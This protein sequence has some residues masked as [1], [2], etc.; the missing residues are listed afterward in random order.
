MPQARKQRRRRIVRSVLLGVA[1][2]SAAVIALGVS[3]Y[4]HITT[5]PEH[6]DPQTWRLPEITGPRLA[7][8]WEPAAGVLIA[9]PL[10]LPR[11]LVCALAEEVVLYVT[12]ADDGARADA[13][14]TL[15]DWGLSA[16]AYAFIRTAQGDGWYG[17][18]DWGP[19]AVFDDAGR[20][21]LA[22][23]RYIDYPVSGPDPGDHLYWLTKIDGDLDFAPDDEAPAAI[24]QVLDLPRLELPFA[25]TGGAIDTD[26]QGTAFVTEAV[27]RENAALGVP[28]R[29]LLAAAKA[30]LGLHRFIILPN[31][32]QLGVHHI[33]CLMKL[34]DEERILVI[35]PPA[36][37]PQHEYAEKAVRVLASHQSV[38]GRPYQ[39]LRIDTP[40]YRGD[41]LA[42]YVN[43]LILN[44]KVFVPLFG[45]EAEDEAL[46]VWREVMP[47][48]EVRG[49]ESAGESAWTYTDAIHCR[50]KAIWD[51]RPSVERRSDS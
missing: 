39:I 49:F 19:F 46:A 38:S 2:A 27:I 44:R 25:L 42:S 22:D 26:G 6:I 18:R 41:E 9:W 5:P 40:R 7:A 34:L 17:T 47:G 12:V 29:Q 14:R 21:H 31:Y 45:I 23:A 48:H 13:D 10:R 20:C 35:R 51:P 28:K 37:H 1:I 4:V 15:R 3:W 16:E 36:D 43:A 24:A 11:D 33:D 32:E 8:E 50:T 30:T